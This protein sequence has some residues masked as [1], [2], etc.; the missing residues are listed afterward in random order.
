MHDKII[1]LSELIKNYCN[2]KNINKFNTV[3]L[4]NRKFGFIMHEIVFYRLFYSKIQTTKMSIVSNINHTSGKL[5][6]R[7]SYHNKDA[8]ISVNFYKNLYKQIASFYKINY[9]KMNKIKLYA[10]YGCL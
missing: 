8:N 5:I 6:T 7:Q 1:E 10:V 2:I 9:T 3:K 4:R